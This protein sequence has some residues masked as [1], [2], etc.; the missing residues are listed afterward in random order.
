MTKAQTGMHTT[1]SAKMM[2]A[3]LNNVLSIQEEDVRAISLTI[4]RN[5]PAMA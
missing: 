5:S 2:E 4:P 3:N 1:T